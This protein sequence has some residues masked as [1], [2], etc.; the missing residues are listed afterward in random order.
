MAG[1]DKAFDYLVPARLAHHVRVGTVV[2][3]PLHG[4]RVGGWVVEEGV[5][6]PPGVA[7]RPLASVTGW[8]PP[9][10]LVDLSAWASWRWAGRQ[11]RFLRAASPPRVVTRLPGPPPARPGHPR[12]TTDDGAGVLDEALSGGRA[13]VRL[14][15]AGD[16]LPLLVAA[17]RLGDA[18][19]LAPAVSG[20]A[21][22]AARLEAVGC[23]VALMPEGWA[24]GAAG[25][26]AVLGSR[27]A[28]WAPVG[29]LAAVVVLDA[30][31]D[32]YQEERAPT[33]SAWRVAAER[34]ERRRV[35]CVLVSPC[36]T[37]EQL[38]WGRLVTTSRT[39]ERGG[40]P[41][42]EVVD[43]R[44]DDPREGLYSAPLV[45]LLRDGGRLACVL[46]RKGR[47]RLLACVGCTELSR[48]EACQGPVEQRT[49][50]AGLACR[51]CGLERPSVCQACGSSRLKTVRVGVSRVREEL[52]ALAGVPVGEVTA[53]TVQHP[54]ARVLVGT[55]AVLHRL[56]AGQRTDVAFLDFDQ[57]L[58]APRFRAGEQAMALLARAARAV[59]GREGGGRLLIQTR[60]PEH[61][62][63]AAALHADPGRVAAAEAPRRAALRLPPAAAV[64][65]V[66]GAQAE[67]FVAAL[68][69]SVEVLGPDG[70][71][72]LV[73]ATDHDALC[74]ALAATPRPA[75]RLRV[76]VDPPRI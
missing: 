48:C 70:G 21:T 27:S 15:P 22:L 35:P 74:E 34:A 61:E 30:H 11:A 8:G 52:E 49:G 56:P 40:W 16:P 12:V 67:P 69:T 2:R 29:D 68:G 13:V 57:E 66:S 42:V 41:A 9:A 25:G 50:E 46:N 59:G 43:R 54:T 65:R 39:G 1:I 55:E 38:A 32:S 58:L 20:A 7:L 6:P 3:V 75:G 33:W 63:V 51:R 44:R 45:R 62:V 37:L 71:S 26:R 72:W 17:S 60:L 31:D 10:E 47:A 24:A 73:R 4:R 19:F 76:E 28:A 5:V 36:P 53:T 23:P 18:L 64:A 14:P